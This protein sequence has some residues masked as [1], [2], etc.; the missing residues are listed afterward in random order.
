MRIRILG[1]AASEGIPAMY[2]ECAICKKAK[3]L[4]GREIRTRTSALIDG[5]LK[6][7]HPPDSF[8]QF[9]RYRIDYTKV[10]YIF[11]THAHR[12]HLAEMEFRHSK[13]GYCHR[14]SGK[15]IGLYGPSDALALIQ[16]WISP[17]ACVAP[18]QLAAFTPV[19][20]KPYT[21]W[22][23]K[24]HHNTAEPYN[25][26]VERAGRRVLYACDTGF[27]QQETWD[28]LAGRKLDMVVADSTMGLAK[29]AHR[30]HMGLDDVVRFRA[31]CELIG[32]THARTRWV[33][34]HFSHNG[35]AL[36][37]DLA[38]AARAH[39]MTVAYDGIELEV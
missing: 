12:D 29:G 5:L 16:P 22:P 3:L 11:I 6:I 7:D 23:V 13:P 8:S 38:K 20:A 30:H 14:L 19:E 9:L 18:R 32:A 15:V 28:F 1:T 17:D 35:R 10:R 39:K 31:Q 24:A 37:R 2:C 26:I 33:L 4:G 27:Y 25:Y 34:S 36:H 21:V